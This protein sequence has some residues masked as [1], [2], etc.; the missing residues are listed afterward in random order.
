MIVLSSHKNL[1]LKAFVR[2]KTDVYIEKHS[3]LASRGTWIRLARVFLSAHQRVPSSSAAV[4]AQASPL[5][6]HCTSVLSVT[7]FLSDSQTPA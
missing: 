1:I 4:R 6:L 3:V 5:S 7:L 2:Y